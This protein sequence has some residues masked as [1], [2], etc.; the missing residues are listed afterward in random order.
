M[1]RTIQRQPEIIRS[2]LDTTREAIEAAAARLDGAGRVFLVGTGTSGHAAMVGEHLL[3]AAGLDAYAG[4]ALD[5]VA[6]PR[7]WRPGDAVIA[8]S[9]RG[10]KRYGKAAIERAQAAGVPIIGLTGQDS[11]MSGA[12][13]QIATAPQEESSTHTASY[14]ANLAAL[15]ALA[16]A[17]GTRRGVDMG[18]LRTSVAALPETVTGLLAQEDALRPVAAALAG[19]GRMIAIGAGPN[20]ATAREVALKVKE[21]SYLTAEGFELETALHGALP[22]V[23]AGDLAVVIAAAGPGW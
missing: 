22:A 15:A 5:F 7:P 19:T 20:A 11:P 3:R 17:A 1:Y 9:H 4:G 23:A 16:V 8:I 6:Y 21:S 12:A 14:T 18:E 2:V 10:S 13:V